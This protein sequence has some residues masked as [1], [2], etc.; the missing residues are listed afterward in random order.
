MVKQD[1]MM[2]WEKDGIRLLFN[3]VSNIWT[4]SH[5]KRKI[6]IVTW[7][8]TKKGAMT[9]VTMKEGE[10]KLIMELLERKY[11]EDWYCP[12]ENDFDRVSSEII[13][14][15]QIIEQIIMVSDSIM[16]TF[17]IES[18]LKR[19]FLSTKD[20]YEIHVYYGLG[21]SIGMKKTVKGICRLKAVPNRA[22]R[23][24]ATR[25]DSIL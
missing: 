18:S 10:Y 6:I 1:K 19:I 25:F 13:T 11:H 22:M 15:C 3:T 7:Q 9:E 4:Y 21:L 17:E 24:P 20:V 8:N 12:K 14:F 5:K 2:L 16:S 23:D